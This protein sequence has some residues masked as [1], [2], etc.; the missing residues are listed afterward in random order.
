MA[1]QMPETNPFH[2]AELTIQKF[3][4]EQAIASRLV[5]LFKNPYLQAH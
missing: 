1:N 5:C 2:Q 4:G 3:A